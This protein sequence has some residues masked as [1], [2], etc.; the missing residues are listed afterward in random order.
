MSPVLFSITDTMSKNAIAVRE[1]VL[2]DGLLNKIGTSALALALFFFV[3]VLFEVSMKLLQGQQ[4]P[5]MDILKPF[6]LILVILN[7]G[8][9]I[10]TVDTVGEF[11]NDNVS[12]ALNLTEDKSQ[13]EKNVRTSMDMIDELDRELGEPEVGGNDLS[14]AP[15]GSDGVENPNKFNKDSVAKSVVRSLMGVVVGSMNLVNIGSGIFLVLKAII[16]DVLAVLA[17]L[18]LIVLS[19][20]GPF[21]FAFALIPSMNRISQWIGTYLQYWLWVPMINI[22]EGIMMKFNTRIALLGSLASPGEGKLKAAWEGM[23]AVGDAVSNNE[24]DPFAYM[25]FTNVASIAGIF[26]LLAIP[27]LARLVI[28]SGE[29]VLSANL[30]RF[31]SQAVSSIARMGTNA[32][33]GGLLG[34]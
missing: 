15:V 33:T 24:L 17:Q 13:H 28:H 1:T 27:K 20:I 7:W 29:D 11:L 12:T 16:G 3:Y 10:H 30:G 34:R 6:M 18:Y 2:N 19:V 23:K 5:W 25:E 22:V 26:L 31:A 14:S 21:A 9:L 32:A 8:P 4:F